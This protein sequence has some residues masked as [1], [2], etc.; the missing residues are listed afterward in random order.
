MVADSTKGVGCVLS[1]LIYGVER[2]IAL[3][4]RTL[5][6]AKKNY[7]V[8]DKEALAIICGVKKYHCYLYG[9]SFIIQSDHKPLEKLLHEKNKL[10][11][12]AAPRIKRWFLDFP[13]M[14]IHGNTNLEKICVTLTL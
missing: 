13:H 9:R 7:S 4:S 12:I 1:H 6:P 10:S 3:Y 8:L 11:H 14:I 2:P 5:K